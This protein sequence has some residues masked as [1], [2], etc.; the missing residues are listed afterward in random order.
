MRERRERERERE[1]ER[2]AEE[3]WCCR[4]GARKGREERGGEEGRA[5]E[6]DEEKADPKKGGR[7]EKWVADGEG[8][9]E[10][11]KPTGCGGGGQRRTGVSGDEEAEWVG[12]EEMVGWGR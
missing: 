12:W 1:R 7:T 5:E 2:D 9:C 6:K 3:R 10:R 11:G 4:A 8:R